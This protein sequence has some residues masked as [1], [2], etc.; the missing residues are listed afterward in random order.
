MNVDIFI[1]ARLDGKRLSKKHL[2]KINGV[3]IIEHLVNRLKKYQ[4]L[5]KL[6]YVPQKKKQTMN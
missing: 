5:V 6:S 4:M 2:R 1:P 3:P